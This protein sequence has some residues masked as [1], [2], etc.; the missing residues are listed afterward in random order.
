MHLTWKNGR[1]F[2]PAEKFGRDRSDLPVLQGVKPDG[3]CGVRFRG[4]GQLTLRRVSL[5]RSLS[6]VDLDLQKGLGFSS[7]NFQRGS[8]QGRWHSIFAIFSSLHFFTSGM[9]RVQPGFLGEPWQK[10]TSSNRL[11]LWRLSAGE[12]Q[13]I[14]TQIQ[15]HGVS[16]G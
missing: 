1:S 14:L 4:P 8:S 10:D 6:P 9:A 13:G 16:C 11:R 2:V 7:T 15:G 3:G 12:D 5:W